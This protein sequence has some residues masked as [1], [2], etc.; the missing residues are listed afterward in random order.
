MASMAGL[1][2][3]LI[4]HRLAKNLPIYCFKSNIPHPMVPE[5][6]ALAGAHCLWLDM[7]HLSTTTETMAE[8]IRAASGVDIDAVVRV[9]NGD[10]N[11]AAKMLDSGA[12]GIMYPQVRDP[13]DVAR[14]VRHTR[15]APVGQRGADFGTAAAL[16]GQASH[17][18]VFAYQ[19]EQV[20]LVVQIETP[21]SVDRVDE[22]ASVPGISVLFIGPGDLSITMGKPISSD[23]AHICHAME[24]T[25]E[26][27]EKY[28]LDWGMP[29][30][31][32]EHAK[33][34]L[35]M[36]GR[37]LAQGGDAGVLIKSVRGMRDEIAKIAEAYGGIDCGRDD[38]VGVVH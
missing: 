19:N 9:Q 28:G 16:Y 25:A 23:A 22:I 31:N 30:L 27:S 21:E 5:L 2:H 18:D 11:M 32:P 29:V 6:L 20:K 7:E 13:E 8:L 26:A 38:L 33:R 17:E 3:S 4:H 10:Y 12:N 36:G 1:R 37:F 24:R 35:S 34:M 14:L 15:Y